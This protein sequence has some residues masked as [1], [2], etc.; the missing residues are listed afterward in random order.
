MLL[1]WRTPLPAEF[2]DEVG[3]NLPPSVPEM[4]PNMVSG[5]IRSRAPQYGS[6]SSGSRFIASYP[7]EAC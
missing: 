1:V 6:W 2:V 7:R 3:E 4:E 5:G